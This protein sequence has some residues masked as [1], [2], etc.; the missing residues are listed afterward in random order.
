MKS[1]FLKS[2]LASL[3]IS[4]SM[5][6]F[7]DRD[8]HERHGHR[9]YRE[10]GNNHHRGDYRNG[11][12]RVEGWYDRHGYYQERRVC[13]ESRVSIPG[14]TVYVQPPSFVIQPPGIYLR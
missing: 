3:V 10:H 12:C 14:P 9:H 11:P 1:S 2:L 5:P 4:I 13:R 6:A 7:A 8:D